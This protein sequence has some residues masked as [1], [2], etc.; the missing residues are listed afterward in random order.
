MQWSKKTNSYDNFKVEFSYSMFNKEAGIDESK[1]GIIWV[2]GDK[3]RLNIAGQVVICDGSTAWTVLADDYEVMM[4]EVDQNDESITPSN[5]LNKYSEK[6]KS[7]FLGELNED[8]KTLQIIELKPNEG[9][10]YEKI[11]VRID[12]GNTQII[13]FTIFDKNGSIYSYDIA[14]FEPNT[15]VSD[16]TFTFDQKEYPDFDLIDMR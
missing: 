2:E 4:N 9:K 14:R 13:S 1:D 10:N 11:E 8:G 5:L 15:Q 7:R 3:Y 6:Y 16:T 12:K